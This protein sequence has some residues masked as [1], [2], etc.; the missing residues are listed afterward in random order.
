[1]P[2]VAVRCAN[3]GREVPLDRLVHDTVEC[4]LE[5]VLRT[6][7]LALPQLLIG[8]VDERLHEDDELAADDDVGHTGA[9]RHLGVQL[10]EQQLRVAVDAVL[11]DSASHGLAVETHGLARATLGSATDLVLLGRGLDGPGL[12]RSVFAL[13]LGGA[14]GGRGVRRGLAGHDGLLPTLTLEGDRCVGCAPPSWGALF[15]ISINC[16]I[17]QYI[18]TLC[19]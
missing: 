6:V 11:L 7:D 9:T 16:N 17:C 19:A 12:A 14:L 13:A 5:S 4:P 18:I 1:M 10:F 2:G 3:G 8:N 15:Y